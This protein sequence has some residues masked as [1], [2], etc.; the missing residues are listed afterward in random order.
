MSRALSYDILVKLASGIVCTAV[1]YVVIVETDV[2]PSQIRHP[3]RGALHQGAD[4]V[5]RYPAVRDILRA[6]H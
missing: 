3:L 1:V 4:R 5:T 6:F 2:L